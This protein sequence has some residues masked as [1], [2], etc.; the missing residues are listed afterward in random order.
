MQP[1]VAHCQLGLGSLSIK[2]GRW[3][4]ARAELPAAIE[5]Y[6]VMDMIFWMPKA[7]AAL[8]QV[9]GQ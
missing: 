8:A 4:D 6:R 5:L 1:L 9:E 7:E 2:I 3:E